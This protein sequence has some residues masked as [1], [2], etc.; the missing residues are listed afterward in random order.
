MSYSI[1]LHNHPQME[2]RFNLPKDHVI[3]DRKEWKDAHKYLSEKT[4]SWAPEMWI[5]HSEH[6]GCVVE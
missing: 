4:C 3:V 6:N 2:K 5:V 1:F